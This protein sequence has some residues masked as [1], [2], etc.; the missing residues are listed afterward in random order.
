MQEKNIQNKK[1]LITHNPFEG[2]WCFCDDLYDSINNSDAVLVLTEWEEYSNINWNKVS[3]IMRKPSWIF[4]A[5]SVIEP[6]KVI[7][8]GLNLWRI[9]DGLN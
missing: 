3:K 5:R 8:T 1:E 7:K 9:G 6:S 2:N 4:D